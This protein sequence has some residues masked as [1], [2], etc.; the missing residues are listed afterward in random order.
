MAYVRITDTIISAVKQKIEGM[1]RNSREQAG[2]WFRY[3]MDKATFD[4]R[5]LDNVFPAEKR[6]LFQKLGPECFDKYKAIPVR[7][8]PTDGSAGYSAYEVAL[9]P[10]LYYPDRWAHSYRDDCRKVT[11]PEL[12]EI[13]MKRLNAQRAV[14]KAQNE[15]LFKAVEVMKAAV[16]VNE[17]VKAWPA[18]RDLLDHDVLERLD[19]K[20]ER[21]TAKRVS[22]LEASAASEL[23]VHLLKAKVVA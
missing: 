17:I 9:N 20:V 14:S 2:D 15:F 22:E 1:Y 23:S 3:G 11:D 12:L 10:N 13:N 19:K 4:Q 21:T 6:E 5:I 8:F 16:S 7:F 18:F